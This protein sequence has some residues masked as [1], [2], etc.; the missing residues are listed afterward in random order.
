V[1]SMPLLNA[2]LAPGLKGRRSV[3]GDAAES[4]DAG[5]NTANGRLGRPLGFSTSGAL[6]PG[7]HRRA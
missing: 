4:V 6:W 2:N 3:E 5:D 1:C 7:G